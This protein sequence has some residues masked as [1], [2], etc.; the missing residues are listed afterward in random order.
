[1]GLSE[2]ITMYRNNRN[3]RSYNTSF[4][5]ERNFYRQFGPMNL[6]FDVGANKGNK[7]DI[8]SSLSKQVVSI[9]PDVN[10]YEILQSR[11]RFNK[12]IHIEKLALSTEP[13]EETFYVLEEG[14][15]LNTL[16][17]KWKHLIEAPLDHRFPESRSFKGK[18]LVVTSTL[19]ALIEQ[20]GIPDYVKID[21]EGYESKV[22]Q[23]LS[24]S[25]PLLS[26]ESNIPEFLEETLAN[27]DALHKL[28]T[29]AIF[30][31]A[32]DFRFILSDWADAETIKEKVK[33]LTMRTIEIY[34]KAY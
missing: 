21:V 26:F 11:F 32:D 15:Q 5:R 3:Y 34:C 17:E 2:R 31:I 33:H 25:V 18:T 12:K 22:L 30:N 8:F 29:N 1:M 19:D 27:V 9:D 6:V 13:G 10:N 23:G 4:K 28:N 14:N 7:T 24:Y 20:Y 16:S